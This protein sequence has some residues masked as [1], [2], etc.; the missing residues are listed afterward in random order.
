MFFHK[1][2]TSDCPKCGKILFKEFVVPHDIAD[3]DRAL[4]NYCTMIISRNILLKR[5]KDRLRE[6]RT[7]H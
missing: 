4:C 3:A 7:D 2:M 6:L 1:V 5:T